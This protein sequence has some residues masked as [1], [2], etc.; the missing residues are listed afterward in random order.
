MATPPHVD[1]VVVTGVVHFSLS[2]ETATAWPLRGPLD[3]S[4]L[5]YRHA[6]G[7]F[8]GLATRCVET[9]K[10]LHTEIAVCHNVQCMCVC[11]CVMNMACG[12]REG[13]F[14]I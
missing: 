5:D 11:V 8:L 7:P 4:K 6:S 13:P 3:L 1:W 14:I 12:T 9:K 2:G 10:K